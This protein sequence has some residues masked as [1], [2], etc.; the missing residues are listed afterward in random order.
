MSCASGRGEVETHHNG[1]FSAEP[2][3]V[4]VSTVGLERTADAQQR[5]SV[6]YTVTPWRFAAYPGQLLKTPNFHIYTTVEIEDFVEQLPLFYELALAHYT[7]VLGELPQPDNILETYLFHDRRQWQAKTKQMLPNQSN[8]FSMLGRGGFTTRGIAVLY[9]IDWRNSRT[10]RDTFA[11]AAHE[12]W[13][14]YT[15]QTFKHHLPVWLEEG[16]AT[17]MESF[18]L[19]HDGTPQFRPWTNRERRMALAR[20]ARDEALIPLKE[21]LQRSPQS[22]LETGR[23]RLLSYYAQVWALTRFLVEYDE[24][25]YR[26]GLEEVL[27]DAAHG[28]LTGRLMGSEAIGSGRRRGVAMTSRVGPWIILEYMNRDLDEFEAQYLEFVQSLTSRRRW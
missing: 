12:G 22:F 23:D 2:V 17:Y 1:A 27:Q 28:R 14:Q 9:Y 10:S 4:H 26:K 7:T 19:A 18:S 25:R 15:Q 6:H 16:L 5:Q 24:G 13:H 20:A 8:I 11:I 3:E 21:L